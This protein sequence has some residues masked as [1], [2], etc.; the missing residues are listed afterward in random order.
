MLVLAKRCGL[1]AVLTQIH[2]PQLGT[3]GARSIH[4]NGPI[5]QFPVP[6]RKF[7]ILF[8]GRDEFSCI[9]LQRLYDASER[10][11]DSLLSQNTEW[12]LI[13]FLPSKKDHLWNTLAVVTTPDTRV[14]RRGSK[15]VE[16]GLLHSPPAQFF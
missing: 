2:T 4:P 12:C 15:I 5:N 16:C 6:K 10:W 11:I 8:W 7:D 1:P 14:I 13:L 9:A 3:L